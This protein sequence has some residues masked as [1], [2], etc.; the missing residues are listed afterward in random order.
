MNASPAQQ[1]SSGRSTPGPDVRVDKAHGLDH[2]GQSRVNVP[3]MAQ[4]V[5]LLVAGHVLMTAH[6]R[7]T[8][9]PS[10]EESSSAKRPCQS[11][12]LYFSREIPGS[13]PAGG[14]VQEPCKTGVLTQRGSRFGRFQ[15]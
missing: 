14:T 3:Q 11:G 12:E 5:L 13:N 10:A 7:T 2:G 6:L 15:S 1:G 8:L 4:S 9:N